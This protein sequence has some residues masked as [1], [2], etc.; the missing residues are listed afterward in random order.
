MN[1]LARS[2]SL[3]TICFVFSVAQVMAQTELNGRYQL[4]VSRSENVADIVES[5][6]RGN[7]TTQANRRD[8]ARKLEAP[9]TIELDIRGNQVTLS[10][11]NSRNPVRFNADGKTRSSTKS[12]GSTVSVRATLRDQSLTVSS[13]GGETDYTLMFVSE[14]NGRSM[15]VTR[16]ITTSYL[17]QTVFADSFYDKTDGYSSSDNSSSGSSSSSDDDNYSSSDPQDDPQGGRNAPTVRKA[18]NGNYTVPS[19]MVLTG[20][21]ENKISTKASQND[22]RFKLTIESPRE[23]DGAIIEGYLSNV[24]RSGRFSGRSTFTMNFETIR[25]PNGRTYDF[26]GVLQS[27]TD[28]NG[29]TIRTGNEGDAK[30]KSRTKESIKRGGIGAGVGAILGG[31]LGGGKGAIIGATIGGGAG[32]G[33][34]MIKGKGDVELDRGSTVTI[35]STSPGN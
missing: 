12:D 25:M 3:L 26:A 13:F 4:D 32:A 33:S 23:Y 16:R 14:D 22:D 29:K 17:S 34:V 6:T 5:A 11:S 28:V 18:G 27:A 30:G 21:L 9:E 35:E 20:R 2:I 19:G 24:K 1:R 15:R 7:S 8:L 10:T 31:I